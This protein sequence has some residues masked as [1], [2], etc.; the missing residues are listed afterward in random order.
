MKTFVFD[1]DD[2]LYDM[3]Q[4]FEKAYHT[5]LEKYNL[6]VHELFVRSRH[7]SDAIFQT[8]PSE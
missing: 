1:L 6:D 7:Y 4:P 8:L 3:I 2:T 5:H